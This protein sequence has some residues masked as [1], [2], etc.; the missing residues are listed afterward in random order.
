MLQ[1]DFVLG[2]QNIWR[3][4][5]VGASGGYSRTQ[6]AVGTTNGAGGRNLQLF[7]LAPDTTVLHALSGFWH[8]EDL[9]RELRF[10][11]VISRLWE[12]G[13]RS[14]GDKKRMLLNLHLAEVRRHPDET[15]A[16]SGWQNFDSRVEMQR[17]TTEARDTVLFDDQG[18]ITGMKPLNVLVHERVLDQPFVKFEDFDIEAFVDY[19]RPFYDNNRR[20]DRPH[21]MPARRGS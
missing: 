2:W 21:K 13:E 14:L 10:A 4:P 6:T 17:A 11:K 8:P 18:I 20:F 19:G 3:Q 9:A 7:V 5:F 12:D 16:R 1:D 15:F